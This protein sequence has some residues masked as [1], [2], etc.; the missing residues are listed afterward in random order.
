MKLVWKLLGV[1]GVAGIA[2]SGAAVARDERH[3]QEYTP[4]QVR[5]RLQ[6]RYDM[7]HERGESRA[8]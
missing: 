8:R 3:R 1:A 7:T 5:D 4:E 6:A 2:A